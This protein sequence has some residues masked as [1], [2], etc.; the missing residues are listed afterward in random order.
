MKKAL[1]IGVCG[2]VG[3]Y[4]VKELTTNNIL[5]Y[6]TDIKDS[7]NLEIEYFKLN[8]LDEEKLA[9]II[10]KT[11]PDYI[12]NLAAVSSVKLSWDNPQLTFDINVKGVINL[13]EAVK[14]TNSKARILLIGSSEQYGQIRTLDSIDEEYELNALNPYGISKTTQENIAKMYIN[15]Y[16]L[17]II[18]V[19]AFNHIG[20]KQALGFAVSDFSKQI[21]DIEKLNVKGKIHVGN[22]SAKRD[23]TDVRDIVKAYR[24][25]LENGKNGEVYNIGSGKIFSL[26]DILN[27]LIKLST[28]EVEIV[29]DKNKFRPTD[30]P[31]ILCNNKKL[32]DQT[33]WKQSIEIETTLKDILDYWRNI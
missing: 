32:K 15:V 17:D 12:I 11:S 13:F 33:G 24:L 20:P 1:V 21:I 6:G 22:L 5:C 3:E 7:C 19:R 18:M 16:G 29:I 4:L 25:L 27:K 31:I 10:I 26:E 9:S 2:F 8:L 28:A 23:F 30:T 14:K